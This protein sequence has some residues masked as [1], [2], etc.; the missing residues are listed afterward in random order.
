[1]GGCF[2]EPSFDFYVQQY[3]KLLFLAIPINQS[4]VFYSSSSNTEMM[5]IDDERLNMWQMIK[6]FGD[7]FDIASFVLHYEVRQASC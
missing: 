2:V 3:C 6:A 7:R 4:Q 5:G 1:M